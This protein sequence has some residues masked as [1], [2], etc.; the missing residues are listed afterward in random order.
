LPTPFRYRRPACSSA[1]VWLTLEYH[2]VAL[3]WLAGDYLMRTPILLVALGL[4]PTGILA[5]PAVCSSRLGD[6]QERCFG[7]FPGRRTRHG[8]IGVPNGWVQHME[9]V[10]KKHR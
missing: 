9:N 7:T 6:G 1:S 3:H 5:L 10:G 8:A 2:Q 4:N